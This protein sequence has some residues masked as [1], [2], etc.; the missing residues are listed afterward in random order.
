MPLPT[1]LQPGVNKNMFVDEI[2]LT[3]T[4]PCIAEEGSLQVH[5][6]ASVSLKPL[7]PYLNTILKKTNYD[8]D[9]GNL[10]FIIDNKIAVA[11]HE[12][13]LIL[14]KIV[15]TTAA[16]EMLDRLKDLFNDTYERRTGIEPTTEPKKV[17]SMVTYYK[18][19]PRT[20]CKKCGVATCMAF[21]NLLYQEE[22]I[23]T[24]CPVL[25]E[26]KYKENLAKINE[27]F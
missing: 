5:A 1:L 10:N 17:V 13:K 12:D 9:A 22:A 23:P 26:D 24:D 25:K 27:I 6:K 8:H 3:K 20:N 2:A 14:R 21:A 15:N 4:V 16:Y 18:L 19:L 11:I 7:L